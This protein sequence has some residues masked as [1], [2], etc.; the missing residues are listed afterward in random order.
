MGWFEPP[1][2]ILYLG[3]ENDIDIGDIDGD[4]DT[5]VFDFAVLASA[6]GTSVTP[7]TNEDYDENGIV[8]V[9]DFAV[10]IADFGCIPDP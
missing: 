5:D 3:E 8:D 9:F 2:L 6:F 10:F 4:G 1:S 7:G